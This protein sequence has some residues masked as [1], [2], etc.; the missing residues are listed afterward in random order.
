[1][2]A[3]N[4][5]AL[6]HSS[7]QTD[8]RTAFHRGRP[9]PSVRRY[10]LPHSSN[11]WPLASNAPFEEGDCGGGGGGG[12]SRFY[13]Q[14]VRQMASAATAELYHK[15]P[16]FFPSLVPNAKTP[17]LI[18]N[19]GPKS[20]KNSQISVRNLSENCQLQK[21]VR[22]QSEMCQNSVRKL[23]DANICQNCIRKDL[24]MY[25]KCVRFC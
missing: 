9:R 25:Q 10:F 18:I 24:E 23:S 22:N 21:S 7:L 16:A 17:V 19:V 6:A 2:M 14:T 8:A 3:Q 13:P 4:G 15:L 20:F 5:A 11:I 12:G 1:M